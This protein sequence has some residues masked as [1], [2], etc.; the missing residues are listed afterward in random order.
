MV[1]YLGVAGPH[2]STASMNASVVTRR[3][4]AEP[5]SG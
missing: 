3:N 4:F 1:I 5:V 2:A